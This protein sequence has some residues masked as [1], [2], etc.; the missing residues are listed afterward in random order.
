MLQ[1]DGG[2]A[3]G[4]KEKEKKHWTFTIHAHI[5]CCTCTKI[6][7]IFLNLQTVF[8]SCIF[9]IFVLFFL[10]FNANQ[11]KNLKLLEQK[12]RELNQ[13]KIYKKQK[14]KAWESRSVTRKDESHISG[15]RIL[16]SI[17]EASSRE[18]ISKNDLI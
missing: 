15:I 10:F 13:K 7:T 9:I 17:Q 1:D 12:S 11:L 2:P 4:Q 3:I 18:E 6:K 16:A 14:N 8:L 5:G